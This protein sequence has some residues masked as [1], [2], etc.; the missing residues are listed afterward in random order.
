MKRK[1]V[2]PSKSAQMTSLN[3]ESKDPTHR[4]TLDLYEYFDNILKFSPSA[5]Q[6]SRRLTLGGI[7]LRLL[8]LDQWQDEFLL[9]YSI[10]NRE[11]TEFF[12]QSS[13]ILINGKKAPTLSYVPF[14]CRKGEKIFGILRFHAKR[15]QS[16]KVGI[17]LVESGGRHRRFKI[18]DIGYLF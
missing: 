4:A 14:S 16:Q 17:L 7:T 15:A 2:N 12:N 18:Y 6:F 3:S 1:R 13:T 10:A 8:S 9:K 11:S 5:Y